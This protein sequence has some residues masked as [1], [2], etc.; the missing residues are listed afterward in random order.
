MKRIIFVICIIALFSCEDLLIEEPKSIVT[1]TFYN[2]EVEFE[3][4]IAGIMHKDLR[5][6]TTMGGRYLSTQNCLVDYCQGRASNASI[7]EFKQLDATNQARVYSQWDAFYKGIQRANLVILK[8]PD[9]EKLTEKGKAKYIGEAKFL[10][11]LIYFTMVRNWGGLPIRTEENMDE[12]DV[13][14]GSVDEVYQL[15]IQDLL[16]AEENLPDNAPIPGRASKWAAKTVLADVYFYRGQYNEAVEKALEVINSNKYAL[17]E[18]SKADDFLKLYGPELIT[19]TE[20]IFYIK[21]A[22]QSGF[23]FILATWMAHPNSGYAKGGNYLFYSDKVNN[24][25]M[26]DWDKESDLRYSYGWYDWNLGFGPTT[27]LSKKYQDPQATNTEGAGCDYTWYRYA[28]LLLLY[29]EAA[30]HVA[31]QPTSDALEKLNMVHRRAYG[32]NSM[33]ASDVDFILDDYNKESFINLVIKERGYETQ[34]EGKRW[35]DLKRSGKVKEIIKAATG[36]DV[37]EAAL[38]WP[39][40]PNEIENNKAISPNEQNPGY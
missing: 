22:R 27:I 33:I 7:S 29:A 35:L 9:A 24:P 39:I 36:K 11:S 8:A 26:R 15:I 28:D 25:V 37:A 16:Y 23:G 38:L 34:M 19:S 3:S 4:A 13:P 20:E 17:V 14:R 31:G 21:Y 10:R 2:T 5:Q 12:I 6:T 40:P 1:E 30:C 32:K 18:I